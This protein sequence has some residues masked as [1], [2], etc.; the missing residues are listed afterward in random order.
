MAVDNAL[1]RG[2]IGPHLQALATAPKLSR[3]TVR[4]ALRSARQ[5]RRFRR[6]P[7]WGDQ[8]L[9]AG[10]HDTNLF[11]FYRA[12]RHTIVRADRG[13]QKEY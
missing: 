12:S 9:M 6:F 13:N 4:S 5:R 8:P 2:V 7:R 11:F 10:L 1:R 3:G